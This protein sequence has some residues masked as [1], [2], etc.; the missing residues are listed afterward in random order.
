M[1]G[2][3][4]DNLGRSSG[5]TKAAS[6]GAPTESASNPSVSTNPSAVGTRFINTTSGELFVCTDITAGE[7]VWKGQ[8]DSTV[9]PP[10]YFGGRGVWMGGYI[11]TANDDTIDYVTI[12]SLGDAVDFGD[13]T[14]AGER[15]GQGLSNGTRGVCGVWWSTDIMEYITFATTGNAT[16]FGDLTL[17][18]APS[19]VS[20]GT[21]G[22]FGGGLSGGAPQDEIDYITIATTGNAVD[23]GDLTDERS[24]TGS[25]SNETRGLWCGGDDSG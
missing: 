16:N 10:K 23:F 7:N 5:L 4:S 13:V 8:L 24:V 6:T 21:R 22:C 20:N 11:T 17:A 9:Q 25:L 15:V 12:A 2:K 1:S 19:G 18:R 3:V 14:V